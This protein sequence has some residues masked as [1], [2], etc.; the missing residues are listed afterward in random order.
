M[1]D[2]YG[3]VAETS[4]NGFTEQKGYIKGFAEIPRGELEYSAEGVLTATASYAV[5]NVENG[6]K[7]VVEILSGSEWEE[8]IKTDVETY[9]YE[10]TNT[11]YL[12]V[13]FEKE[14][15]DGT[16]KQV[17]PTGPVSISIDFDVPLEMDSSDGSAKWTE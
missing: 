11:H 13:R 4:Y 12:S 3:N 8:A 2:P 16:V 6:A 10:L 1:A 17:E 14:N 7:L 9:G 15:S 5:G